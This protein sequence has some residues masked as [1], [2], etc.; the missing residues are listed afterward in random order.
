MFGSSARHNLLVN[1]M[2]CL[3][4]NKKLR[5]FGVG[6]QYESLQKGIS[7]VTDNNF[8]YWEITI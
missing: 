2:V 7:N 4:E 6:M 1:D 5:I 8:V 3:K